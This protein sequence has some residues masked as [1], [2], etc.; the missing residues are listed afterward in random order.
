MWFEGSEVKL[1]DQ[2]DTMVVVF[3]D[4]GGIIMR[5][6]VQKRALNTTY[7]TVLE[8][9]NTIISQEGRYQGQNWYLLHDDTPVLRTLRVRETLASLKITLL[10]P[11]C[12]SPDLSPY[13]FLY[14]KLKAE[15][16]NNSINDLEELK[17]RVTERVDAISK[18][19]C[20]QFITTDLFNYLDACDNKDGDY[21]GTEGFVRLA[22]EVSAPPSSLSN[23]IQ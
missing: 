8:L 9:A 21:F 20:H 2:D 23:Y 15:L 11:K 10:T 18:E 4:S 5:W 16:E 14:P 17:A 19:E 3:F 22:E 6:F 7:S 12:F 13:R 1:E